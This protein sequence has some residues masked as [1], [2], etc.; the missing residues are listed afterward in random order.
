MLRVLGVAIFALVL[1]PVA[2]AST[3][4]AQRDLLTAARKGDIG[5]LR[6]ALAEGA[7]VDGGD[8]VFGQT[9]LIR[10]AM[11]AQAAS[12][13]ALLEAHA[14]VRV[15]AAP[16]ARSALHW[17][18]LPGAAE[19]VRLL[20]QSGAEVEQTDGY[21]ETPLGI[22]VGEGRLAAASALIAGG[23]RVDKMRRPLSH[24]IGMTL[25]TAVGGEKLQTLR[26]L[27]RTGQGLEAPS[28]P[29]GHTAL[30][31]V[32][33]HGNKPEAA[34]LAR[35]LLAAGA[36]ANAKSREGRTASQLVAARLPTQRDPAMRSNL[37]ALAAVLAG[38]GK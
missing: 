23:A 3:A 26:M 18:A 31:A 25:G 8:P 19:V 22:A 12:V 33:E 34:M 6:R 24:H 16:E 11:F 15:R 27:I 9:A 13:R 35:E 4:V 14:D 30:I 7:H 29:E 28:D 10:A 2:Y 32:A 17:A 20:L 38:G 21:G 36:N 37:E 1:D 5:T